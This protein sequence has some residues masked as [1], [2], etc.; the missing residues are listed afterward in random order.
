ML[1]TSGSDSSRRTDQSR[2]EPKLNSAV[3]TLPSLAT[4]PFLSALVRSSND[5]I[6]G[7][8]TNG[9]VVFWNEAAERL[10]GYEAEEMIGREISVLIPP[11]RPDE[12][13][14]LLARV[15]SGETVRNL[16]TERLRKDGTSIAVSIT[17]SPVVDP[18]GTVLGMSTIAH[19]LT[20]YNQQMT[21]L[22]EA[23]RRADET[24]STLETLHGSAPVGLGFVDRDCR[25]IH[26]NEMFAA[27]NGSTVEEQI[28][29]TV[30][31]SVPDIWPQI[32][33]AFRHVL[34]HD[35]CVLNVEASGEV[36]SDPGHQRHW[37]AN[38]YPVH[39][40]AEVIG[41]GV[42][43]VDVTERR[44]AEDF[45]SI[46]M[47]NMAEGLYT[48]DSQ[49]RLTSM[50]DAATKM[51]GWTEQELLG[52]E[53]RQLVLA[54]GTGDDAIEEGIR[55]LLSVR[56]EGR[57][58]RLDDHAYRC[59]NGSVLP[60][61]ISA[62]PLLSSGSVEGAV[63]VF[64][65]ITEEKSER[66]RVKR[67]MATLSWVGRIREA[68]DENRLILYSQPIVPLRGGQPSEE[69]L[70]RMVGRDGEI[71]GPDAFLGVA[72][73]YGLITEIDR[74]VV[75]QA[76]RLAA[77]GR[78]VGAN[79][80]A[81]SLVTLDMLTLIEDEVQQSG[82]DPANLVFEITETAI[83]RDIETCHAFARGI[84]AL[85][86]SIALDDFGT[87]FGT[88]TH[89]KKLD[90]K[91]LKIDIEFVRGLVESSANQ[92]VVKAIVNLA[93]GFG[94]ETIAEGVEDGETLELLRE[95]GVDFAQGFHLGRP[96]PL[97]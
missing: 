20:Q 58:V 31:E 86:C 74:W 15:Q 93:Q 63:I 4:E 38:Y 54:Q 72:E 71:I 96:A 61:A 73:K 66:L 48:V 39:L 75:K 57:H 11:D 78:H 59:K 9:I 81:E 1:E 50:N 30:A 32:E 40:D 85:G 26:L 55:K 10:Y 44:Q 53:M 7:K 18:D 64:R 8:T 19:D 69:L 41:V 52:T 16:P 89:V 27:V 43:V 88:F 82:A 80:S 5:A 51:L 70:L 49:G 67:E 65:D 92:H 97:T 37:L 95:Y 21:D 76:A 3:D 34:E 90:V 46:V 17:V 47:N 24:L 22:R 60:V 14:N 94:C 42:V 13:A 2:H 83:M 6:I 79:L 33:P 23:H 28:G 45:R 36:V 68:L 56:G 84:V 35:E 62:S 87:G 25:L 29:K 12:L 91:Y 77:T